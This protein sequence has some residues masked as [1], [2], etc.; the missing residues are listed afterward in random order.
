MS[1][2]QM[3]DIALY[4]FEVWSVHLY[5]LR[6]KFLVSSLLDNFFWAMLT[7]A[8]NAHDKGVIVM[9]G[10][11]YFI[12]DKEK[13]NFSKINIKKFLPPFFSQNTLTL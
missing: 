12:L 2:V 7:C 10:P 6:V 9:V 1:L 3:V 11:T 8:L 13:I 5:I 4:M